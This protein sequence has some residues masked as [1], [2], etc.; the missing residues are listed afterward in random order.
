MSLGSGAGRGSVRRTTWLVTWQSD[1]VLECVVNVSEGR[2][3][4]VLRDLT[5]A[6][7]SDLLDLHTDSD[8]HRS[9]FTLVGEESVRRLTRT[10]VE[11]LDLS[12]HADGVHPRLGV[13]DVVPFVPL[14]GSSFADALSARQAFAE[15]AAHSLG[16][17][18]FL[19]GPAHG[20]LAVDRTLPDVRRHAWKTLRPDIGPTTPHVTAGAICVGARPVLVAYNIWMTDPSNGD[21]VRTIAT[22]MR[23]SDVRTLALRVGDHMQLSM[24]LIDPDTIG[25]AQVLDMARDLSAGSDARIDRCELVGLVPRSVLEQTPPELW[26]TLDISPDRTIEGRLEGWT[27]K[28]RDRP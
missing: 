18:C 21:V 26:A 10:A 14:A 6:C 25:P 15:W 4:Q 19:Y 17:P 11:V 1:P 5:D 23:S 12:R 13:V 8:H 7:G 16:M 22:K 27:R 20:S 2:D 28:A 24:N 3:S 9:V